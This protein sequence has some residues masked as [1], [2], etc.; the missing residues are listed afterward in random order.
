[1]LSESE[2]RLWDDIERFWAEEAEE[3]ERPRVPGTGG[4][5][6]P[7]SGTAALWGIIGVRVVIVLVLFGLPFA[8]LSVAGALAIGWAVVR[9]GRGPDGARGLFSLPEAGPPARDPVPAR[10]AVEW[11]P[12]FVRPLDQP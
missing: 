9:T 10:R 3:P 5:R 8:A 6:R 1:V 12:P 7:Q 11:G 4:R 2:Q